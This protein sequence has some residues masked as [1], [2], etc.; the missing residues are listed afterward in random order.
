MPAPKYF[1]GNFKLRAS[2][3]CPSIQSH[4]TVMNICDK[5]L[6]GGRY[7][8]V[9]STLFQPIYF[10]KSLKHYTGHKNI[11]NKHFKKCFFGFMTYLNSFSSISTR[12]HVF[13]TWPRRSLPYNVVV[14]FFCVTYIVWDREKT[15]RFCCCSSTGSSALR[16]RYIRTYTILHTYLSRPQ[17]SQWPLICFFIK[18]QVI[19]AELVRA[20]R[21]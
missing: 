12:Y 8:H 18:V 11:C 6:I 2:G 15:G 13:T 20:A 4:N 19:Q 16:G 3:I 17:R 9:L 1:W 7:F 5:E 21:E 14:A 10:T